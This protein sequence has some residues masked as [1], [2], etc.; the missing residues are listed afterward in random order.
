MEVKNKQCAQLSNLE[1]NLLVS[2]LKNSNNSQLKSNSNLATLVYELSQYFNENETITS[3]NLVQLLTE[4]SNLELN[5]LVS[6]LKNSNNSQ[7]KSNSNLATLV[8]ELSQYFN[9]NETITSPN[10]VQ[11]LTELNTSFPQK[12]TKNE[13][14]MIVNILPDTLLQLVLIIKD[15]EERLT[16][17]EIQSLLELINQFVKTPEADAVDDDTNTEQVDD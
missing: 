15:C 8:Y 5:L 2:E 13:K 12:L 7:L 1:L 11:L 9:E 4:L 14:L 10:L 6:E 17:Q 16:E 3:P